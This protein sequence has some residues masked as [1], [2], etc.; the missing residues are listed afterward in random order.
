MLFMRDFKDMKPTLEEL[1]MLQGRWREHPRY[2]GCVGHWL[3]NEGGGTTLYDASASVRHIALTG[4]IGHTL[5]QF[6]YCY[7]F[8]G[9][10]ST[11]SHAALTLT[12]AFT[13]AFWLNSP[14]LS[15][16]NAC[17]GSAADSS[18]FLGVGTSTVRVRC[19]GFNNDI[20]AS[21]AFSNNILYHFA[22]TRDGS[23]NYTVFQNANVVGTLGGGT[24]GGLL[25]ERVGQRNNANYFNGVMHDIYYWQ[26][27]KSVN[28]IQELYYGP[29]APFERASE[30]IGISYFDMQS[31]S[32]L[33]SYHYRFML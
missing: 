19:A 14:A 5:N 23:G 2:Q 22:V 28:E 30:K 29:Y 9:T 1:A 27:I 4:T 18:N 16:F 20:T 24:T 33:S 25:L 11:G 26:G 17:M 10:D 8:N 7:N 13:I 12:G 21:P 31:S 15:Q 32:A 6:G 3:F